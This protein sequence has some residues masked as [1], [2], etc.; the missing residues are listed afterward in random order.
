MEPVLKIKMDITKK[1]PKTQSSRTVL[2]GIPYLVLLY[3]LSMGEV[4]YGRELVNVGA[5]ESTL[6]EVADEHG[7][8]EGFACSSRAVEGHDEGFHW[9]TVLQELSHSFHHLLPHQGLSH[10]IHGQVTL[11]T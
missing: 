3:P 11:Q 9:I 1:N 5:L 10:H 6:E 8:H 4:H 2:R 7:A